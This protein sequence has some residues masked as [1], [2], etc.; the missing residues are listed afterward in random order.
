MAA[1]YADHLIVLREGTVVIS[2]P[3]AEIISTELIEQ[4]FSLRTLVVPD[5][6]TATPSVVPHRGGGLLD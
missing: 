6:V 2:G 4:V 3:P 5:P 1:R